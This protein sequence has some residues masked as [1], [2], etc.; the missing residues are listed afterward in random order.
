MEKQPRI[1]M[2]LSSLEVGGTQRVMLNLMD[3]FVKKGIAVDAVVVKAKGLF[4]EK[5]PDQVNLVDLS[6]KRALSSIPALI[7]Y[8]R[9]YRPDAVFSGLTHI[10]TVAIISRL[11]SNTSPRL[12]VSERSNLTQKR[13]HAVRFW[14]KHADFFI[15]ILYPLADAVVTVSRDAATDIIKTTNLDPKKVVMIYNPVPVDAIRK[16]SLLKISPQFENISTPLIL[17]VGR[18]SP[19][20]DYPTLIKAFTI[21]RERVKALL[22]IIGEGEERSSIEKLIMSSPYSEDIRLLGEVENPYPYM[23]RS[24]VFVLSSAWEGFVNVLVE[25]LACGATVVAS[26]CPSSPK[27]ILDNGK[28]GRLVP[29]GDAP[30]FADAIEYALN[31][32]SPAEQSI[33]RAR[34]FSEEEAVNNYLKVLLPN[35]FVSGEEHK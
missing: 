6:A 13:Q 33:A 5:L 27:E 25:A 21:L 10:N 7:K 20:K 22:M 11:L 4:L 30:A 26:D 8:L 31:N 12:V 35:Y 2:L 23:A 18:L 16:L 28:F 9:S 34:V 1:A 3:G 29:V 32:P 19:A 15:N 24:N 17:A 14:D